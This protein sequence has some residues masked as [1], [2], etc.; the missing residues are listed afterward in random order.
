MT[1]SLEPALT[2]PE[3]RRYIRSVNAHGYLMTCLSAISARKSLVKLSAMHQQLIT[4]C[5]WIVEV[6]AGCRRAKNFQEF[7][8]YID[9]R[10]SVYIVNMKRR[11]CD[12]V[13]MSRNSLTLGR[14]C[15][16]ADSYACCSDQTV[17]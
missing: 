15:C 4:D 2:V 6:N 8:V 16:C 5:V 3:L 1:T 10:F 7:V 12:S 13:F 14:C 11:N 9:C 17:K